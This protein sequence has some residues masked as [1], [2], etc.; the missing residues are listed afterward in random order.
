MPDACPFCE[1][2]AGRRDPG[3]LIMDIEHV[4]AF[5]ARDQ[6][7][8]NVGHTLV[9]PRVHFR[10]LY[11]LEP[12]LYA[13]LLAAV[14]RIALAVERCFDASGTSIRLNNGPPGQD[15]F[16]AHFHVIPRHN[17][18]ANLSAPEATMP[19]DERIGQTRSILACLA[20]EDCTIA[21]QP[22]AR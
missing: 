10:N 6:R 3:V 11:D 22:E 8:T 5:P 1:V 18:D 9:V 2:I 12:L 15:V 16:H 20:T 19:L 7:Q 21:G 14:R 4:A 17:D 13:P